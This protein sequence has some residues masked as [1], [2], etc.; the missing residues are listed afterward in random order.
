[1][2]RE[3]SRT[4]LHHTHGDLTSLAPHE[5]LSELPVVPREKSDTGAAA[6][7]N[8]QDAPVIARCGPFFLHGQENNPESSPNSI[9]GFTPFTPRSGLQEIPVATRQESG[10]LFF[11]S[12]RGLTLRVSRECNPEIPVGPVVEH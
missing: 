5:R 7:E 8:P 10:V 11:P 3:Q 9:G 12:R 1:M 2:T 6:G 4:P